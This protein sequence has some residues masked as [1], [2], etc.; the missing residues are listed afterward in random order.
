MAHSEIKTKVYGYLV[1]V[2]VEEGSLASDGDYLA[3]KIREGP[4]FVEGV[5]QVNVDPLGE[6]DEVEKEEDGTA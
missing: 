5:K 1:A 4:W 6:I 3:M 2:E